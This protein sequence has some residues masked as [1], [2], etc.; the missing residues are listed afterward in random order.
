MVSKMYVVNECPIMI[1]DA[2]NK[3]AED[4]KLQN[5]DQMTKIDRYILHISNEMVSQAP[6]RLRKEIR[7]KKSV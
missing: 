4:N 2:K 6:A 3:S 5:S 1:N 7:A